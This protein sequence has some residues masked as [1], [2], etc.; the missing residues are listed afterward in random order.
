MSYEVAVSF[1][2]MTAM[3]L[4]PRTDYIGMG[5]LLN[6]A[7]DENGCSEAYQEALTQLIEETRIDA[8]DLPP[9]LPEGEKMIRI[10]LPDTEAFENKEWCLYITQMDVKTKAELAG[11]LLEI[12]TKLIRDPEYR[13]SF[14]ENAKQMMGNIE[15]KES[16]LGI[17]ILTLKGSS[18]SEQEDALGELLSKLMNR[19]SSELIKS[20]TV[21]FSWEEQDTGVIPA[22]IEDKPTVYI[23]MNISNGGSQLNKLVYLLG[24][25]WYDLTDFMLED[26]YNP[27]ESVK[28]KLTTLLKVL[29]KQALT[30]FSDVIRNRSVK[31]KK[32]NIESIPVEYLPTTGLESIRLD[33][34]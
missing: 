2:I 27:D 25:A 5:A 24:D 21:I 32:D 12:V 13:A 8:T 22:V 20:E 23:L 10:V 29:G 18:D 19:T 26:A 30:N 17:P 15:L 7:L 3:G 6:W 34:Q 1:W 4:T 14:A 28:E 33:L 9:A 31:E 16:E 11:E